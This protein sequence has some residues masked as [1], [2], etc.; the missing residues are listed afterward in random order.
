VAFARSQAPSA[1]RS[2][3]VLSATRAWRYSPCSWAP[4]SRRTGVRKHGFSS[5]E[6][7]AQHIGEVSAQQGRL[8][9]CW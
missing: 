4:P 6:V 2:A 3:G 1:P 5:T 7:L 9:T 8:K